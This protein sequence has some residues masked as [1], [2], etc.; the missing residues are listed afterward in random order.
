MNVIVVIEKNSNRVHLFEN[1]EKFNF[2]K[3]VLLLQEVNL[4]EKNKHNV[5]FENEEY[6]IRENC[7]W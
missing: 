6:I 4:T 2:F 5:Y 7:V 1:I 3:D